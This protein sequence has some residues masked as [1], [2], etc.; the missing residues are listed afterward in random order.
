MLQTFTSKVIERFSKTTELRAERSGFYGSIP[1]RSWEIFSS[2]S[3]PERLWGPPN[4]YR[5][6]FPWG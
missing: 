3:C 5:G 6:V 4:G 1:G 2:P